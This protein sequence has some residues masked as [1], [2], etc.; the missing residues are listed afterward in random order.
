VRAFSITQARAVHKPEF[1]ELCNLKVNAMHSHEKI[2]RLN[3]VRNMVMRFSNH[4][5]DA[6]IKSLILVDD[7]HWL[8]INVEKIHKY[9]ED[10]DTNS[11]EGVVQE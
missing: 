3:F 6:D 1:T 10:P 7:R 11:N 4:R 9:V 2:M 8:H 5:E